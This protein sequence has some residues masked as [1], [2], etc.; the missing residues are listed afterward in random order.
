[1][2]A[3]SVYLQASNEA[4][5]HQ[6]YGLAGSGSSGTTLVITANFGGSGDTP[7]GIPLIG[8]GGKA[9]WDQQAMREIIQSAD[10]E[11]VSFEELIKRLED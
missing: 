10:D 6:L 5:D 7:G 4:A 2:A 1:M 8:S 3:I 9:T 11:G